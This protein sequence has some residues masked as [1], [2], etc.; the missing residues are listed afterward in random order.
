LVYKKSFDCEILDFD[1]DGLN[2]VKKAHDLYL[3]NKIVFIIVHRGNL[4]EI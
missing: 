1:I 2:V 4:N 3:K